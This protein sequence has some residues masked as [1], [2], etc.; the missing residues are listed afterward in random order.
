LELEKLRGDFLD[1][2]PCLCPTLGGLSP[3][4]GGTVNLYA[5]IAEHGTI[6]ERRSPTPEARR[7]HDE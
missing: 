3:E 1:A 6:Y 4:D 2:V 7:H 5:N